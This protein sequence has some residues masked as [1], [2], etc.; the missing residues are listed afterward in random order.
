MRDFALR[1]LRSELIPAVLRSSDRPLV[2][3]EDQISIVD[4]LRE[5]FSHSITLVLRDSEVPRL[6]GDAVNCYEFTLGLFNNLRYRDI[7][8]T[9]RFRIPAQGLLIEDLIEA[10]LE[11]L[12]SPR[13]NALVVYRS[14][15]IGHVGQLRGGKVRSK[16]SPGGCV[17]D[18]APLEVPLG[19]GTL[20][21]WATTRHRK[22]TGLSISL[23]EK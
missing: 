15:C 13:E 18:H 5:R 20:M 12:D 19:Y 23:Q 21:G 11:R 10:G 14:G 22:S 3:E 16:W 2:A 17:W 1:G 9:A 7:L 4:S 6:R 8:D